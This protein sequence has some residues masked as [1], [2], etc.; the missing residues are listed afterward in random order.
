MNQRSVVLLLLWLIFQIALPIQA[1]EVEENFF[2]HDFAEVVPLNMA[3][4]RIGISFQSDLNEEQRLILVGGDPDIV[5]VREETILSTITIFELRNG[6]TQAQ[7]LEKLDQVDDLPGVAYT[8]PVFTTGTAVEMLLTDTFGAQ[9]QPHVT[10]TEID[11]FNSIHG[12]EVVR[13]STPGQNISRARYILRASGKTPLETLDLANLYSEDAITVWAA[14]NFIRTNVLQFQPGCS[15][16]GDS[17]SGD[18]S[19][20]LIL[21]LV[22]VFLWLNGRSCHQKWRR[23]TRRVRN[24]SYSARASARMLRMSWIFMAVAGSSIAQNSPQELYY[25]YFDQQIP[26]TMAPD[27]VGISFL[28]FLGESERLAAIS[29]DPDIVAVREETIHGEVTI[30]EL[31]EGLGQ[32]QVLEKLRTF[33]AATTVAYSTPVFTTEAATEMLLTDSFIVEFHA[34]VDL[35]EID[36]LNAATGVRCGWTRLG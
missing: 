8:T 31:R 20:P 17:P 7:V 11:A 33:D 30:V 25:F 34:D 13:V 19:K 16:A 23:R 3:L 6:L 28:P 12:V 18:R 1:Q 5:A 22:F 10:E 15:A 27:R 14:P 32:E 35:R 4:D 9:F 26:L 2:Y 29:G 24:I 21:S 36:A